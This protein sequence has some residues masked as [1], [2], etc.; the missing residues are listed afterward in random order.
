MWELDFAAAGRF[1]APAPSG[2]DVADPGPGGVVHQP[3]PR[4]LA[5]CRPGRRASTCWLYGTAVRLH[6]PSVVP[7]EGLAGMGIG[8]AVNR[9][10]F[11]TPGTL[12]RRGRPRRHRAP[13]TATLVSNAR[14]RGERSGRDRRR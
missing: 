14:R 6:R 7:A 1:G 12:D 9:D 13:V 10:A 11:F 5:A 2:L 8:A 4:R 3:A